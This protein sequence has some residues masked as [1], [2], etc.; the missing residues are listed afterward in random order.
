MPLSS[1]AEISCRALQSKG[2]MTSGVCSR[3]IS[4]NALCD[5]VYRSYLVQSVT[6]SAAGHCGYAHLHLV[7][8]HM[9]SQLGR[10]L[11]PGC[12]SLNR[13]PGTSS[14]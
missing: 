5:A 13:Q 1:G 11:W 7:I 12:Q 6:G 3:Y 4:V 8:E 2:H 9:M 10:H 14:Q